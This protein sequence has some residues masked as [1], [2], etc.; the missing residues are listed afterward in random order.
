[1][2]S[3]LF[4]NVRC[5]CFCSDAFGRSWVKDR[6]K[7]TAHEA[8]FSFFCF[9][10]FMRI[11]IGALFFATTFRNGL[12]PLHHKRAAHGAEIF[13]WFCLDGVFTVR[14]SGATV[15]NAE[16]SVAFCHESLFA[17]WTLNSGSW[18]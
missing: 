9:F 1:M 4:C 14:I 8:V 16:S 2:D 17:F 10:Q 12:S 15:K 11:M 13:R 5:P 6:F 18:F 3:S 7:K